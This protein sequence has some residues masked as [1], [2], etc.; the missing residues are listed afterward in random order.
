[1][2]AG[3][4]DG[5]ESQDFAEVKSRLVKIMNRVELAHD[6][7]FAATILA[8]D[9]DAVLD[10]LGLGGMHNQLRHVCSKIADAEVTVLAAM[11]SDDYYSLLRG[12]YTVTDP[13][14]EARGRILEI[15]DVLD[16][17]R[18]ILEPLDLGEVRRHLDHAL[19]Y[20]D[21]ALTIAIG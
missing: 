15:L 19:R 21:E 6:D 8:R 18:A 7:A 2:W 13:V 14:Y 17:T 3:G 9:A 5:R 4:G 12:L 20:L 16:E 10:L 11:K 1:M